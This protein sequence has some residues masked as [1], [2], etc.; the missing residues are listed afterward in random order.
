MKKKHN[1]PNSESNENISNP[2][3][4]PVIISNNSVSQHKKLINKEII[5]LNEI[6]FRWRSNSILVIF[7]SEFSS[8]CAYEV[9]T[10]TKAGKGEE[11]RG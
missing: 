4:W 5:T 10:W 7:L 1:I 9:R 8:Q 3:F 2:I 6:R 11:K